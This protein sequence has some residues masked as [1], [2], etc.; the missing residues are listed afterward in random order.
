MEES[1]SEVLVSAEGKIQSKIYEIDSTPITVNFAEFTPK[2]EKEPDKTVIFLPGWSMDAG[3]LSTNIVGKAFTDQSSSE[4]LVIDTVPKEITKDSLFKEAIAI[5]R[6]LKERGTTNVVISGHSEGGIKAVDLAT[7]LQKQRDSGESDIS[8]DGVILMESMGLFE[9]GNS[10]VFAAKFV[11]DGVIDAQAQ[12]FKDVVSDRE[13]VGQTERRTLGMT[14]DVV[15]GT[16]KDLAKS[17]IRY[18]QKLLS[19]VNEMKR[20]DPRLGELKTPVILVHGKNDL[21]SSPEKVLPEY[22]KADDREELLRQSLFPN[23]PYVRMVTGERLA[24][25]GMPIYRA[26]QVAKISLYLLDRHKRQ[27]SPVVV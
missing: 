10:A 4:T 6:L 3:S 9:Q 16:L 12:T 25:H 13:G 22:E 5:S 15:L 1:N 2:R 23:S 7:I 8:V 27:E 11:K 20:I 17:N 26:E 18:P 21:V 24:T 14:L 19:Q